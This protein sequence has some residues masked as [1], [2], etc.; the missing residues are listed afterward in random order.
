MKCLEAESTGGACLGVVI[1]QQAVNSQ[2]LRGGEVEPVQGSAVRRLHESPHLCLRD[3]DDA[4]RERN[5][6]IRLFLQHLINALDEAPGGRRGEL[7]A[8]ATQ[9]EGSGC[10][11]VQFAPASDDLSTPRSPTA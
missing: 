6:L 7:G 8:I 1:R 10:T 3:L 4:G 9:K 2:N 5:Q 11:E